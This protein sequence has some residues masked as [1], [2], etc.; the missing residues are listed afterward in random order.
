MRFSTIGFGSWPW[1]ASKTTDK[2]SFVK[3]LHHDHDLDHDQG[4]VQA[5]DRDPAPLIMIMTLIVTLIMMKMKEAYEKAY[6]K[7]IEKGHEKCA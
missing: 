7:T 5:W 4:R 3:M 6:E 1:T 2:L